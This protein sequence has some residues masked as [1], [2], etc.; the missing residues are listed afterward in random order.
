MATTTTTAS[1][2]SV[3]EADD[4]VVRC[5]AEHHRLAA[6]LSDLRQQDDSLRAS[7]NKTSLALAADA[8]KDLS[9]GDLD[10][11]RAI[12]T[13]P[14]AAVQTVVCCVCSLLGLP[15]ATEPPSTSSAPS[16]STVVTTM[17]EPP[18]PPSPPPLYPQ[19]PRGD[20]ATA[21]PRQPH[22]VDDV[23]GT[24]P[25][26][27]SLGDAASAAAASASSSKASPLIAWDA[28]QRRVGQKDFKAALLSFDA[29]R[30]LA[31][32][33]LGVCQAVT[34]RIAIDELAVLAAAPPSKKGARRGSIVCRAAHSLFSSP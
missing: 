21:T 3:G 16:P 23:V 27:A 1:S 13:S 9:A 32:A 17:E 7:V 34:A 20:G 28:A 25:R 33:A 4:N 2:S 26:R 8:V 29:R 15:D 30:L 31:P 5:E 10:E 14:P 11:V 6:L 12:R 18:P 24:P 19:S 22:G